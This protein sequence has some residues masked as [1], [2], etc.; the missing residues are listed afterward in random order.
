MVS[1]QSFRDWLKQRRKSL[2][3]TQKELALHS[4]C[5]IYTVQRIEEG[6]LKPS[7]QLADLLATSLEVPPE[8]RPA[9]VR[10]ARMPAS[11][12]SMG[13]E[14]AVPASPIS[15][16]LGNG[17]AAAT[18]SV[19]LHEREAPQVTNP[20]KGLRAFHEADAPDFFG[21]EALSQRLHERLA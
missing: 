21:R 13:V 19:A 15:S 16:L 8:E 5:S 4:G 18:S 7:R 10:W 20:Y 3:L 12:G 14:A 6:V 17:R 2:D 9:F 1:D 11:N